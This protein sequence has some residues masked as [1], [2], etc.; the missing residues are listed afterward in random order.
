VL[1]SVLIE[2]LG[3]RGEEGERVGGLAGRKKER[4]SEG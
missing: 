3:I 4:R 1:F 2:G